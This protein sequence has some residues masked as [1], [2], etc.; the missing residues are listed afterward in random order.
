[1]AGPDD[2]QKM[3]GPLGEK[4]RWERRLLEQANPGY[5]DHWR[6]Y[7]ADYCRMLRLLN[8]QLRRFVRQLQARGLAENTL[9]FTADHGTMPGTTACS[10]R[11]S[12]SR[13][14]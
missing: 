3:D 8:D 10:A 6:R 1:M 14:A 2:L 13:S 7:R 4:W 9:L 11:R 12:A 5:D